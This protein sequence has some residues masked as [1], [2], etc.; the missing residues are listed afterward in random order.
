MLFIN[1]SQDLQLGCLREVSL[2]DGNLYLYFPPVAAFLPAECP[3]MFN[4]EIK[5]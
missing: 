5:A 2:E 1:W 3:A 4:I